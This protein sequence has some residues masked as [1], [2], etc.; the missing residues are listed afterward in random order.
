MSEALGALPSVHLIVQSG[1][2]AG[3]LELEFKPKVTLW[4][5]WIT[6]LLHEQ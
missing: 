3:I 4:D 2:N 5:P 1:L 6:Q